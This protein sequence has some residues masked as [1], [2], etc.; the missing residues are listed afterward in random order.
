MND[1][2]KTK[3][4]KRRNIKLNII[5]VKIMKRKQKVYKIK[6]E[7]IIKQHT[8]QIVAGSR[9]SAINFII[10]WPYVSTSDAH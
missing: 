5:Y 9:S 1:S 4:T 10:C 3:I 7:I 8:L 6:I 2:F